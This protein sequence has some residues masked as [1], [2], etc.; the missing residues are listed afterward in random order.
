MRA[1]PRALYLLMFTVIACD[2]P[3][4]PETETPQYNFTNGPDEL[5]NVTRYENRFSLNIPD[6]ETGLR[7]FVGLPT[8]PGSF[9]GCQVFGPPFNGTEQYQ[10]LPEQIVGDEAPFVQLINA[11][12]VNIH[13]FKIATFFGFCRSQVYAQGTGKFTNND[14]DLT[15]SGERWNVWGGHI[16]GDV[17]ITETGEKAH[18]NAYIRLRARPGV[19]A[20]I[21]ARSVTLN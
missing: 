17:T 18:L 10:I 19:P 4:V 7:A 11:D 1:A 14:N 20:E 13:V 21:L 15:F 12:D 16:R 3:T 2:T 5:P 8:V 6:P 9:I